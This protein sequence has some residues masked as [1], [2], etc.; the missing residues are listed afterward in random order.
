MD[1]FD[2]MRRRRASRS[3]GKRSRFAWPTEADIP[4]K[5]KK[6]GIEKKRVQKELVKRKKQYVV[7]AFGALVALVIGIFGLPVLY[8][9]FTIESRLGGQFPSG[10]QPPSASVTPSPQVQPVVPPETQMAMEVT[11]QAREVA[12]GPEVGPGIR[13][14]TDSN[15]RFVA[16]SVPD[17]SDVKGPENEMPAGIWGWGGDTKPGRLF[18][19]GIE[20]G[21]TTVKFFRQ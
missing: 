7:N 16:Y 17:G 3:G 9:L 20:N 15:R 8:G 1:L 18:V 11:V 6:T 19:R 4:A 2:Y 13:W 14:T 21:T 12:K 10:S 5:P